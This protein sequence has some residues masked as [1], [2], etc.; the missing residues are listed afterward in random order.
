MSL[1]GD[2]NPHV[3]SEPDQQL[4]DLDDQNRRQTREPTNAGPVHP[5]RNRLLEAGIGVSL[6]V[7]AAGL[8]LGIPGVTMTCGAAA[9]ILTRIRSRPHAPTPT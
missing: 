7:A 4:E 8:L 3:L 6:L 9:I 5:N 1:L 2:P